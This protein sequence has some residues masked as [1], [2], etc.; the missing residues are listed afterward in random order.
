MD[1]ANRDEA[2]AIICHEL[3][4]ELT[5]LAS[6]AAMRRRAKESF[7]EGAQAASAI[8]RSTE[9]AAR[10]CDDLTKIA[11]DTEPTLALLPLDLRDVAA[12]G[13][14]A[15]AEVQLVRRIGKQPVW[16]RGDHVRLG[17]VVLNLLRNALAF[18][19]AGD[20]ITVEV[21]VHGGRAR[22]I[23][24]D[25]GAGIGPAFL[26]FVFEKYSQESKQPGRRGLGLYV[27]RN[28]VEL[29]KGSVDVESG[30]RIRGTRFVVSLDSLTADA[31]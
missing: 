31:A 10:L 2:L 4:N 15:R 8:D 28:L 17:E 14:A 16:V 27:V 11:E 25:T 3:R 5:V 22:L 20:T 12:A 7:R 9:I 1:Q 18:T 21:D 30:G 24:A 19:A 6:W 13:A 23:V 29:H 26:P